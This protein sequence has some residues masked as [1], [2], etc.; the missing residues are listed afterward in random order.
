MALSGSFYKY[1]IEDKEFGLYCSWSGKQSQSGN[2]T[3]I[4]LNVY[5]RFYT[6]EVG[7]RNDSTISI[8]GETEKYKSKAIVD[9]DTKSWHNVLLKSKTVRVKHSADGT[10][11]NVKLSASWRFDGYYSG[12]H[13]GTIKA[14]TTVD[15][16]NITVYKLSVS[17][18]V[19][20]KI[21]VNRTS[22]LYASTGNISNGSTLYSGDKLKITFTPDSN[23]AIST[24]TVNNA[25]F[26]SGNTHTVSGNVSVASTAQVLASA[27]GATDANIG[28]VSTIV[29]TKYNTGYCHS[30][31]YSFG[32]L[33]GYI[34][35]SGD[36]QSDEVK[37][38]DTSIAFTIPVAFYEQIPNAKNG[39]CTITC[40]TYENASSTKVLGTATSC[41]FIA[42]ASKDLCAPS[43][44]A[45]VEDI[46]SVTTK[47]T[48]DKNILIRYRSTVRCGMYANALN[49]ATMSSLSIAG[50]HINGTFIGD[51]MLGGKNF[52]DTDAISFEFSATDSRGYTT[53]TSV[54][55][56]YVAY[57]NLTCNPVV[58]RPT[59]TGN[60]MS[61][62]VSG[63]F[64]RGSFGA[65]SNTLTIEYRYKPEGGSYSQWNT[66]DTSDIVFGLSNY[67][68]VG[69]IVLPDEF[70]YHLAYEFQVRA[71]DGAEE[72]VLS[73]VQSTVPVQRGIPVFDWG[74]NDFNINVALMLSNVNILD[75]MYPIGAVYMHSVDAL[76]TEVSSVGTWSSVET[77]I[78]N[79][80]AW[81][82][83]A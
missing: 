58:T 53:T 31:K 51:T 60:A 65:Y 62:S 40:Y 3:D 78:S 46:N 80:Y 5:V 33:S 35:S 48:G 32:S 7:S 82:R 73:T 25:T 38:G 63:N 75:I 30:L 45:A 27:V 55:P 69:S 17:S 19:G 47:L 15:L 57:V 22:S 77:G 43:I 61:L 28:S 18:G 34:T 2:Y 4:T 49:G 24:H 16:P 81:K 21:T 72:Y 66:V 59:P 44:S 8:N 70:D 74:E 14:E 12:V 39:K 41:T 54:C 37:F 42:T 1:P 52:T 9:Y 71:T 76:P 20:S 10:K 23:Y 56:T 11:T 50:E 26:T 29:V 36:I 64:Y 83:T 6:L 68:T 79:V 67:R 13:I